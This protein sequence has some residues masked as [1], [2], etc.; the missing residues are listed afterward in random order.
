VSQPVSSKAVSAASV[1]RCPALLEYPA[2]I[3]DPRGPR[4]VRHTLTSLLVAAVTR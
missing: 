3:P 2:W 1:G 4:G